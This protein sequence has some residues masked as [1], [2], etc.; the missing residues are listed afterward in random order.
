MTTMGDMLCTCSDVDRA[1]GYGYGACRQ[2]E[3]DVAKSL[4]DTV[5]C[6]KEDDA[7]VAACDPDIRYVV[8]WLLEHDFE[9][10]DSGDGHTKLE[11]DWD[12]R[13]VLS[14]PHVF[15]ETSGDLIAE[16]L[17]LL[18]ELRAAGVKVIQIGECDGD[19]LPLEGCWIQ[20]TY[21]PVTDTGIIE[22]SHLDDDKLRKALGTEV[23]PVSEP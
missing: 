16:S 10:C 19:G 8:R 7:V 17:R 4:A 20:A 9:T 21:D 6:K 22:L 11:A 5:E 12:E 18:N 15:I 3:R 13:W 23:L 2:R 1:H 14:Y